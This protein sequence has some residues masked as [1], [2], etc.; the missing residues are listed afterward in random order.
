MQFSFSN[1]HLTINDHLLVFIFAT[2]NYLP[3][4]KLLP[5]AKLEI[6]NDRGVYRV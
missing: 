3:I 4:V 6:L 5:N 1:F 2:N